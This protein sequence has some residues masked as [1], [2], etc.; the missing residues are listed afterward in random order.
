[1]RRRLNAGPSLAAALPTPCR[2]LS[3][4]VLPPRPVIVSV[5]WL[6]HAA[7]RQHAGMASL[8]D[9]YRTLS[10]LSGIDAAVGNLRTEIRNM[11]IVDNTVL[12]YTS[13]NGALGVGSTAGLSGRKGNLLEGGIRVPAIIEWPSVIRKP[14][15]TQR[16]SGTV[17]IYPTLLE[18]AG[19]EMENARAMKNKGSLRMVGSIQPKS[20][21][22]KD[23][24]ILIH[25][26]DTELNH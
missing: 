6:P 15:T 3:R 23:D 1:M 24:A 25:H 5:P 22:G 16:V 2:L 9:L 17:D 21:S 19:V 12:W 7:G 4:S 26:R 13:D 14:R 18:L 20:V 10:E 8:L 11:G